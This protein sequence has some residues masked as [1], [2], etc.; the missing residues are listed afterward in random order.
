MSIFSFW[1]S[2]SESYL[3][4]KKYN[5]NFVDKI[6]KKQ[7]FKVLIIKIPLLKTLDTK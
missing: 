5:N 3:S 7:T 1:L 4:L 6:W 2:H